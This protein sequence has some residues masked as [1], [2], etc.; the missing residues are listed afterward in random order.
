MSILFEFG[1]WAGFWTFNNKNVKGI[2][3]GWVMVCFFRGSVISYWN[4]AILK[5]GE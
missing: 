1:K 4:K 2:M 3:L 5:G